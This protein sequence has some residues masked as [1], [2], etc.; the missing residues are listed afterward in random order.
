MIL[1]RLRK[2]ALR[3]VEQILWAMGDLQDMVESPDPLMVKT[4]RRA[5]IEVR[6]QAIAACVEVGVK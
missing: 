4:A 3:K 1:Y 6:A 2:A 5:L